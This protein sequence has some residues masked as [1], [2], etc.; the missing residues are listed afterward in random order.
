MSF[1]V[2][3]MTRSGEW[4]DIFNGRFNTLKEAEL[5]ADVWA[6]KDSTCA[7]GVQVVDGEGKVVFEP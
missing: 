4:D 5:Y 3:R 7:W 6:C 2:Q 1:Q